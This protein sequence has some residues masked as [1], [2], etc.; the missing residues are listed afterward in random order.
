MNDNN[1]GLVER[2]LEALPARAIIQLQKVYKTIEIAEVVRIIGLQSLPA[3]NGQNKDIAETGSIQ[4]DEAN[5]Y[6]E[7]TVRKLVCRGYCLERTGVY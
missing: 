5:Q 4:Q 2:C 1:W 7:N 6:V 3:A